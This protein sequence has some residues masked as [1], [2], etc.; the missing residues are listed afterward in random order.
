[1]KKILF[2]ALAICLAFSGVA[3]ATGGSYCPPIT[4]VSYDGSSDVK[5]YGSIEATYGQGVTQTKASE[6]GVTVSTKKT[7]EAEVS[8]MGAVNHVGN[9]GVLG[10]VDGKISGSC[11]ES[12][13]VATYHVDQ[14]GV[15]MAGANDMTGVA[16][17][18]ACSTG[19][20][21]ASG[22]SN[23]NQTLNQGQTSFMS[24]PGFAGV[25]TQCYTGTVNIGTQAFAGK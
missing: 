19:N 13:T 6:C 10:V 22:F 23:V 14:V 4:P 17:V 25:G 5:A 20:A 2:L 18:A 7:T 15:A 9:C 16:G 3:M 1:M 21:G 24:G 8:G 12:F 11:T